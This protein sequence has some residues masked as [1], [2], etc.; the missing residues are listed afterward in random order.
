[1]ITMARKHLFGTPNIPA[2]TSTAAAAGVL[3]VLMIPVLITSAV[4]PRLFNGAIAWLKPFHFELSLSIHLVA[5]MLLIPLL[6]PDWQGSRL[7]R[8]TML[9]AATSAVLELVYISFQAAR[10]RASHFNNLTTVETAAYGAMGIGSLL[11]V[12]ASAI[13]GWAILRHAK[14]DIGPGL[15]WGA[16]W[17]LMLGSAATLITAG[18]MS[19]LPSHL[20]GGP[21]TDAF[22]LPFL[23]WATRGGDLRVP[24]F[25]ATHAM[26]ALPLAGLVAD[27][28]GFGGVRWLMPAAAALYFVGVF[29]LFVQALMGLPVLPL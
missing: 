6:K 22:G 10:G 9:A 27:W 3:L 18:Y 21:Q 17:G 28:I 11:L 1:M 15:K 12:L 26:Q 20:V 13:L 24:H 5:L 7:I 29:G 19:S 8:W 25:F 4:D 14:A 2:W 16:A 23:G